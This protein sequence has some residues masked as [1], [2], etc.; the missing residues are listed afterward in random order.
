ML[1]PAGTP[2]LSVNLAQRGARNS[3][4]AM[5]ANVQ[6]RVRYIGPKLSK[7]FIVIE[8]EVYLYIHMKRV[9]YACTSVL[10]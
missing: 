7:R 1:M 10:I 9:G 6:S 3:F 8:F 4:I 5:A 2:R